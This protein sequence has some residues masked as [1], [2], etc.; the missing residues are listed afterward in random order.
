M[1]RERKKKREMEKPGDRMRKW[2]E[3]IIY[4]YWA[5]F[6]SLSPSSSVFLLFSGK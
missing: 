2:V 5:R 3:N 6:L 4:N 1:K